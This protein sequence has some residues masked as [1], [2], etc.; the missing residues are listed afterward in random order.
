MNEKI[1]AYIKEKI[2]IEPI[3]VIDAN[4]DLFGN[5]IVDSLGMMQLIVF[6][7]K[8]FQVKI[9][10]EDMTVENFKTVQSISDFITKSQT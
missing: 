4:E 6:L 1:I 10:P 3:D 2:A 8:E 7:E 9:G 5:G